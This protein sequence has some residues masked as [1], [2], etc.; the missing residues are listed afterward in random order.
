[1]SLLQIRLLGDFCLT[2]GSDVV[3]GVDT[4]RLQSLLAYLL[5]HRHAAQL[6]QHLA[7]LFWPDSSE[8][9]AHTNLRN[10]LHLLRHALPNAEQFLR[11]DAT[12]LQWI[13]SA[14][15]T[16]D[17][18]DFQGAVAH[19]HLADGAH[20]SA[21]FRAALQ[22]AVAL[23]PGDLLPSC[24]D[25]WIVPERERLRQAYIDCLEQLVQL[26]EQQHEFAVAAQYAQRIL[27]CDPL[28]EEVCRTLMR[29]YAVSGERASAL[30]T[31][32]TCV[33]VLH[34]E[35]GV[36]PA[37][38]TTA[39]YARLLSSDGQQIPPPV[40]PTPLTVAA[41]PLVGRRQEWGMLLDTWRSVAQQQT[42][43]LL[44]Q[45]EPGIG[46]TRL[47]EELV[48]WLDAQGIV[49]A[50]ARCHGSYGEVA[51]EPAVAWLRAKPLRERL[52]LLNDPWLTELARLLPELLLERTD[53][54][55]PEPLAESQQRQRI[56]EALTRAILADK[57]PKLLLLDNL[58]WC[59]R[60]TL[61]W[62]SH[63]LH[64][65]RTASL[66]VVATLRAEEIPQEHPALSLIRELRRE[67]TI[68]E[69]EL[70]RLSRAETVT[71]AEEIANSH[72]APGVAEQLFRETEGNP[73]FVV[74]MVRAAAQAAS[75]DSQKAPRE[76]VL[77]SELPSSLQAIIEAHLMQ[78]SVGARELTGLA[79]TIGREFTFDI[80]AR[81]SNLAENDLV[82]YLD[83]A[84]QRRIVRERGA[85]AYDF[86][87][88]KI[89]EVTYASLSSSRRRTYHR[90][91]AEALERVE[92][93]KP[94]AVSAQLA[95]HHEQAGCLVEAIQ[96]FRR[97]AE[98][99]RSVGA[100]MDA[101][102]YVG[103]GLRL[104]RTL[105]DTR[106]R[107]ELEIELLIT[108]GSLQI[109]T[110]G[111]ADPE[112]QEIYE[113]AQSLCLQ[114]EHTSHLHTVRV[115]RMMGHIVRSELL[116]ARSLGE[117]LLE[118]AGHSGDTAL[119]LEAHI[120]LGIALFYLGE[121]G[122]ARMHLEAGINFFDPAVHGTHAI[123]YG[124]DPEVA[125]LSYL[126]LTLWFLGYPDQAMA[127]I[128]AAVD[129]SQRISH[130]YSLAMALFALG[131]LHQLRHEVQAAHEVAQRSTQLCSERGFL[132]WLALAQGL[133]TWVLSE[134][135]GP[136]QSIGQLQQHLMEYSATGA[137]LSGTY[138][139]VLLA[140]MHQKM[141]Q[142]SEGLAILSTALA[143]AHNSGERFYEAE[144]WRLEG[145]LLSPL[146]ADN[147]NEI[148][149]RLLRALAIARQQGA[150]LME[151][152]TLL[153]FH[154]LLPAQNR[155]ANMQQQLVE[156][157]TWF[158]EGFATPDLLEAGA[159][160][161]EMR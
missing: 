124:Q 32:H 23:Y 41:A 112:V 92:S 115:G 84:W 67:N 155:Q 157:Y 47:A 94:G 147:Q 38:E 3:E 130:F 11:S 25:D 160:V 120:M 131:W 95:V 1:M 72:I 63:L 83:E 39:A 2:S 148:E 156:C 158:S 36:E 144:L 54:P 15:F 154:R 138:W 28:R 105:P 40:W 121:F 132:F 51:F 122:S 129:K 65:D 49:T 98:F 161:S 62:L 68:S 29:L 145:A 142:K 153:S 52:T 33:T 53:L 17:V 37:A 143:V 101:I 96:S 79:A 43:F 64:F 89:R 18:D 76:L 139:L 110:R 58:Q 34:R 46:K 87:H 24:Y 22:D 109:A 114:I 4:P 91:V 159:V 111:Y 30:R 137:A 103:E 104:L 73:L 85:N 5:L 146:T 123:I 9:Q 100:N 69:I 117:V 128:R 108:S 14:P 77:P 61:A 90:R 74:E 13:G 127:T 56:F 88:D 149:A 81:A 55:R 19:A 102:G 118:A 99:A 106:E 31:Y 152:R 57:R 97:A 12:T 125:G 113:R 133:H 44:I 126:G 86:S 10:L 8:A 27:S 48:T 50:T 140:E 78:L 93:G 150:K 70:T 6:R 26:C 141:D 59:D 21:I 75:G 80:L 71:L 42:R 135:V 136:Q 45:G 7:F 119:L 66:F 116:L 134:Q 82:R 16:L 20:D 35:L 151:L 107:T 60:E